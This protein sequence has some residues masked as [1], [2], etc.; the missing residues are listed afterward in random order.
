VKSPTVAAGTSLVVGMLLQVAVSVDAQRP[1][2]VASEASVRGHLEFLAGDALNGR[3]S[4]TRDEWIAATYIAAQLRRWGLE[5]LGD[6]GGFVQQVDLEQ[7]VLAAA[8]VLEY[9]G[10]RLA[11]GQGMVV[12]V[13]GTPRASGPLQKFTAGVAVRPGAVLVMP[14]PVP[15]N[16]A[17]SFAGAALVLVPD[18]PRMKQ[19]WDNAGKSLPALPVAL[20]GAARPARPTVIVLTRPSYDAVAALAEGTVVSLE[21]ELQAPSVTH[22]WNA[23]GKISGRD[24]RRAAEV[25][26]LSAHLD[27]L[28]SRATTDKAATDNIFNGADDDASGSVAV[29]ELAEALASGRRPRRT[30]V[31]VWFGSEESGGYGARHFIDHPPVPLENIVANLEFEMIGRPDSAVPPHTLWLTGYERSDLGPRLARRGAKIVQDPHPKENF[32]MRS[33][34]IALARRGVVAQTVSSFGLHDGYHQPSDEVRLVDFPHMTEAIRSML[35]PV[36]WLA[37]SSFKPTWVAGKRP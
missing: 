33:D 22:T 6:N 9:P 13:L 7:G 16:A 28:G 8:P 21:A 27:H 24:K 18:A 11:H 26:L 2:E 29:L 15:P 12:Q 25:L 34:N 37:N 23:I 10:S 35:E 19:L 1:R 3:G 5:P 20:K 17:A 31:F 4:G 30:I 32:F 14:D 36:R